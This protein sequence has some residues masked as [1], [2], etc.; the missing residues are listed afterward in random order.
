[1]TAERVGGESSIMLAVEFEEPSD[2]L[3][4]AAEPV[5]IVPATALNVAVLAPERTVV[6]RGTVRLGLLDVNRSTAPPLVAGLESVTEQVLVAPEPRLVGLHCR[7][8]RVSGPWSAK[9]AVTVELFRD[10]VR[11]AVALL[12]ILPAV[13]VNVAEVDPAATASDAGTVSAALFEDSDTFAPPVGAELV[14]VSVQV[15]V[16]LDVNVLGEH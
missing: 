6:E 7:V 11:I 9:L 12:A 8:S 1:M 4:V 15:L 5:E 2:A 14:R 3:R 10:A 16:A 13:A